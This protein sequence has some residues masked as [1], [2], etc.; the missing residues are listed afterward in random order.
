MSFWIFIVV[1]VLGGI[2]SA[3]QIYAWLCEHGVVDWVLTLLKKLKD[4]FKKS[5]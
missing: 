1:A 4:F 3:L 5:K 2:A